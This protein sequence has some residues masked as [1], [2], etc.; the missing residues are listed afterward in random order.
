MRMRMSIMSV[1]AAGMMA[2]LGLTPVPLGIMAHPL[3][4][5]TP[6]LNDW[7]TCNGKLYFGTAASPSHF[8]DTRWM[9]ILKNHHHFGQVTP[10]NSQK[11]RPVISLFRLKSLTAAPKW[12]STEPE[13]GVFNFTTAD[14]N[15]REAQKNNQLVRCHTLI[16]YNDLPDWLST[17]TWDNATLIAVMENHIKEVVT[18]FRGQCRSWDVVNE[19]LNDDGTYRQTLW[20]NTIGPAYISMAYDMVAKYDPDAKLYYND[21]GIESINNKS[22]AAMEL[23]R[24]LKDQ[25]NRIDGVGLQAHYPVVLAP[26]YDDQVQVMQAFANLGVEVALTELDVFIEIPETQSQVDTQAQIYADSVRACVD[27]PA[28]IGVTV[29]GFYDP[30]SWVNNDTVPGYG[31]PDLWW[32]NYTTKPAY[33][34]IGDILGGC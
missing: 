27:V 31:D 18:H 22:L 23:V 34:A 20:Y 10:E 14:I 24:G 2:M 16:W 32:A 17:T 7:M 8:D 29:W 9:E 6:S 5:T 28:C 30:Y 19:A 11:V 1:R 3:N 21:Y 26:S 12:K 33:T 4:S 13:R 25:G 15:M